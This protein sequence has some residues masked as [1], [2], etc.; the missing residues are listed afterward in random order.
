MAFDME[1]VNETLQ[2][3]HTVL[4]LFLQVRHEEAPVVVTE[5]LEVI[6]D[7]DQICHIAYDLRQRF[8]HPVPANRENCMQNSNSN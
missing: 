8:C 7:A 4:G 2:L 5:K 6:I 1:A 3:A